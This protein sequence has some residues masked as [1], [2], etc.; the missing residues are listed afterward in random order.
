MPH[1]LNA[2][3]IKNTQPI[4]FILIAF[5][6]EI[7]ALQDMKEQKKF[8]KKSGGVS[9]VSMFYMLKYRVVFVKVISSQKYSTNKI[10]LGCIL[11]WIKCSTRWDRSWKKIWKK[12]GGSVGGQCFRNLENLMY[13]QIGPKFSKKKIFLFFSKALKIW[14]KMTG[15]VFCQVWALLR[16][17]DFN[18][19]SHFFLKTSFIKKYLTWPI[20]PRRIL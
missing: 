19:F 12:V 10:H 6:R 17:I 8:S 15:N 9:W 18:I 16:K 14:W 20:G 13:V 3:Q 1:S 2:C 4:K 11:K 5:C 7:I